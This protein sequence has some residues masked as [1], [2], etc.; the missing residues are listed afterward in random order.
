MVSAGNV[1]EHSRPGRAIAAGV[2][3]VIRTSLAP[4]W[5]SI[6]APIRTPLP[7]ALLA[8]GCANPGPPRP[9]SLNLPEPVRDLLASRVGDT[10]D[11][12]WTA[13]G[14]S[15]DDL[16]LKGPVTAEICEAPNLDAAA[17]K[18]VLTLPA[19]AGPG[20]AALLLPPALVTGPTA[21]LVVRVRLR[22]AAGRSAD[23]SAPAF[24]AVGPPPPLPA[25]FRAQAMQ[26]G[27]RLEWTRVRGGDPVLLH[28][29]L[30]TPPPANSSQHRG[31]AAADTDLQAADPGGKDPGGVLDRTAIE[32]E[33]YRY[34]AQRLRTA[35]LDGQ[36][37][38]LLSEPSPAVTVRIHDVFP[39]A[40]PTG[41]AS[42]PGTPGEAV[43][44]IELSWDPNAEADLAGYLVE[45][46]ELPAGTHPTSAQLAWTRI[47]AMPVTVPALRDRSVV[48]GHRYAYRILAV[49]VAGNQSAPSTP[50]EETAAVP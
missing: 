36:A 49:D 34:T 7:L 4:I 39:P 26:G 27:A 22:N 18:P 10:I 12:S 23:L 13:P 21:L 20:H 19:P 38:R 5:A 48:G 45:R 31:S 25:E 47:T 44:A 37:V 28:R 33:T 11:L 15:T 9:P 24:T 1:R 14:K 50:L 2:A 46:T 42:V 40:A 29:T 30:L 16:P 41:L 8:A 17:C 3:G 6:W 32:G 35:N 43:A